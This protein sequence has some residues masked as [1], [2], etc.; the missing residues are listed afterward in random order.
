MEAVM[1]NKLHEEFRN[2]ICRE[3]GITGL[4]FDVNKNND[5]IM[6]VYFSLRYNNNHEQLKSI[7]SIILN[8]D[9]DIEYTVY[10]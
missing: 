10:T 6:Y 5:I 7:H 9:I 3:K 1:E 2:L 4:S 8:K